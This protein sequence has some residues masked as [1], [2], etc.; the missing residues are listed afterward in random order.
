MVWFYKVA[1]SSKHNKF[2]MFS[3]IKKGPVQQPDN[4]IFFRK[5]TI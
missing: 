4:S 5:L 1:L 3:K 2:I